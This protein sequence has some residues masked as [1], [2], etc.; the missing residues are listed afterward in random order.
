MKIPGCNNTEISMIPTQGSEVQIRDMLHKIRSAPESPEVVNIP[1]ITVTATAHDKDNIVLIVLSL[2]PYRIHAAI[3]FY[4]K[5]LN[6]LFTIL[7]SH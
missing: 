7:S 6:T 2:V 5:M 3:Y 4:V 1:F